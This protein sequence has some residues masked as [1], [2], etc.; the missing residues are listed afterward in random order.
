MGYGAVV[1]LTVFMFCNVTEYARASTPLSCVDLWVLW[2]G[3]ASVRVRGWCCRS[4]S[5][6][7][8]PHITYRLLA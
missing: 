3:C 2:N 5:S 1:V 7:T 8:H 6:L 4:G